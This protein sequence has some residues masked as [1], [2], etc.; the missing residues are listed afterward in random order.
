MSEL[1]A[2]PWTAARQAPLTMKQEYWSGFPLPSPG[3]FPSLGI[4][5]SSPAWQVD[6]LPLSHLVSPQALFT[7]FISLGIPIS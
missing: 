2:N 6:S 7:G 1:F 5:P 4:K 3:D